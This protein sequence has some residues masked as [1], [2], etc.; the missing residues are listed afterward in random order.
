V[1]VVNLNLVFVMDPMFQLVMMTD[2]VRLT[3]RN[4]QKVNAVV[5]TDG[6]ESLKSTVVPVVN[7]NSVSAMELPLLLLRQLPRLLPR[8]HLLEVLTDVVRDTVNVPMVN[9][10]VNGAGVEP[11]K[12]IV[13]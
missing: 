6:V 5:S 7:P 10:A 11:L 13:A 8:L 12:S 4:A 1:K 2:V 9:A 3:E